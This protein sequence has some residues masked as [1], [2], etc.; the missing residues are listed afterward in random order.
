MPQTIGGVVRQ[1]IFNA[2]QRYYKNGIELEKGVVLTQERIERNR[3]LYEYYCNLWTAYPDLFIDMIT[4]SYDS[5]SLFFYQRI[6]LRACMRFQYQY[7]T[8]PRAFSKTFITVLALFLKCMFQPRSKVFICAP[9]KVQAAKNTK[10]KIVELYQHW[11]ILKREVMGWEISD[12][13]GNFGKDYIQITF[14]N[15]SI[16]DV[17]GALD[18]TRGGRRNSGLIDEV[19]DHDGDDLNEIVLP[20]LNVDR[21]MPNGKINPYE[22]HK[23]QFFMTSAAQKSTYA[24]EKL[25]DLFEMS[26]IKPKQYFVWGCDYR[27]PMYH[28]LIS[29][30]YISDLRLSPTF[31]EDSFAREYLSIWTGGGNDS[32]FDFDKLQS[33]R[34]LV[35]PELHEKLRP[36]CEIFYLLAVDVGRLSCQTVVTVFKVYKN[37]AG[38][39][40]SLVNI[41]V[42]GKTARDQHFEEQACGLKQMIE[43]YNAR[44]VVLDTNGLGVGLM[45][46]MVKPTMSRTGKVY[47]AYGSFNDEDYK[48]IQPKDCRWIIYSLKATSTLNPKIHSNCY[49]WIHAGKVKFLIREQDAKNKLMSTKIGQKMKPEERTMRLM[50][51]EMTTRLF[52]EMANLRL[53]QTGSSTDINLEQINSRFG[54]DK[55]SS[56]EYGLWRLND[57]EQEYIKLSQRQPGPRKLIFY[58][59]GG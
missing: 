22:P 43:D 33:Y 2:T 53:K 52:E 47:P 26:I 54:K 21:R 37:K 42:L 27:V 17:V 57:I 30:D 55:F 28:G 58:T 13:P 49:S 11:P 7:C 1:N 16:L 31:K 32:W 29:K 46:F 5:F 15:G 41:V 6:F 9:A 56:F 12:T 51:H 34:K 35:N 25:L 20:L 59:E 38:F 44:E 45:D 8:A 14:R 19:R 39:H 18:S 36:D 50:P 24:Y 3:K 10:E 4:P 40:S 23:A 48:K